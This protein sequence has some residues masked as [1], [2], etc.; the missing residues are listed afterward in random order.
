MSRWWCSMGD[1]IKSNSK[2]GVRWWVN[3]WLNPVQDEVMN[4]VSC[5]MSGLIQVLKWVLVFISGWISVLKWVWMLY[6]WVNPGNESGDVLWV[7]DYIINDCL[8]LSV[9]FVVVGIMKAS[10]NLWVDFWCCWFLGGWI[11][12]MVDW[13]CWCLLGDWIQVVNNE[14]LIK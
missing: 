4:Q 14:W 2:Y 3:Q 12:V 6:K 8:T 1:W 9:H 5:S 11:Q 13:Q 10:S 7:V